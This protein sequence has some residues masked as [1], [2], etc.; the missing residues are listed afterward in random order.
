[1][2][3]VYKYIEFNKIKNFYN[4]FSW[5]RSIQLPRI[6]DASRNWDI[7]ISLEPV[8]T[9]IRLYKVVK[10]P[11]RQCKCNYISAMTVLVA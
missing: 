2:E 7:E 10:P 4:S 5:S 9:F 1:M 11:T 3:P 8:S 6:Y